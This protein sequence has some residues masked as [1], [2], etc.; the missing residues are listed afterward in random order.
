MVC[1]SR[2]KLTRRYSHAWY[3]LYLSTTT[4]CLWSVS[5]AAA[6]SLSY[7][8]FFLRVRWASVQKGVPVAWHEKQAVAALSPVDDHLLVHQAQHDMHLP[9]GDHAWC[10]VVAVDAPPFVDFR[11]RVGGTT[12]VPP[13]G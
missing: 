10:G 6:S 12:L 2:H 9:L 11:V 1:D 8:L 5:K 4:T 13:F 7:L 3:I